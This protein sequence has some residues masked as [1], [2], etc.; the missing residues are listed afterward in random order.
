MH[1]EVNSN[2]CPV[3]QNLA[4]AAAPLEGPGCSSG[5]KWRHDSVGETIESAMYHE[6]LPRHVFGPGQRPGGSGTAWAAAAQ[7][8][9]RQRL[10]WRLIIRKE[11]KISLVRFP[12]AGA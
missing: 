7:A 6:V 5:S 9:W 3:S 4:M 1:V 11:F 8:G 12:A 10:P 2:G